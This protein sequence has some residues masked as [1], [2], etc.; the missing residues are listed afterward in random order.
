MEIPCECGYV[1]RGADDAELATDAQVHAHDVHRVELTAELV[2]AIARRA[3]A[4][5]DGSGGRAPERGPS[6]AGRPRPVS[7]PTNS[8]TTPRSE[9]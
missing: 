3:A 5:S 2:V 9:T 6:E 8:L 1:A 4:A 7:T